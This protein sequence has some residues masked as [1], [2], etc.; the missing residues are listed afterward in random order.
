MKRGDVAALKRL[1][2]SGADCNTT[3]SQGWT[4]ANDAAYYD[5]AECLGVLADR[6][7]DLDKA[8]KIDGFTP[9]YIAAQKGHAECL[10][11]LADRGADLDKAMNDGWTPLQIANFKDHTKCSTLLVSL[12]PGCNF[13]PVFC[14]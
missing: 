5:H 4:L 2:D 13:I 8:N 10:G 12:F 6:G 7:A 11:V 3:D 14:S 9:A 1:C